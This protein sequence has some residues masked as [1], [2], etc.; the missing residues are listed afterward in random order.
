MSPLCSSA[1][2]SWPS[3]SRLGRP[4]VPAVVTR[5]AAAPAAMKGTSPAVEP[6]SPELEFRGLAK[7]QHPPAW[8]PRGSLH[9]MTWPQPTCLHPVLPEGQRQRA[10]G[11]RGPCRAR[12]TSAYV[13]PWARSSAAQTLSYS[14]AEFGGLDIEMRW[15]S[16]ACPFSLPSAS[17]GARTLQALGPSTVEAAKCRGKCVGFGVRHSCATLGK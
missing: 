6:G 13:G 16:W 15:H 4:A 2:T 7:T 1:R 3:R 17:R 10:G 8:V 5:V 12:G 9:V 11:G 14:Q